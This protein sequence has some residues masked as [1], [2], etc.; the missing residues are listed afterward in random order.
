MTEA[1]FNPLDKKNLGASV[2]EALLARPAHLLTE[3]SPFKGAGVYALYFHGDF[4]AYARLAQRNRSESPTAPI[5]VGKAVPDGRRKGKVRLDATVTTTALFR[6]LKEHA[7]SI[8]AAKNLRVSDFTFRHLVVDDIWIPLGEALLIA[9]LGPIWN[10]LIDGFGNH[11]PGKGRYLG[12]C[13]RWDVLHP[14][15]EW[16][17][18]CEPRP[19]TSAQIAAEVAAHLENDPGPS[20]PYL[21]AEQQ[22]ERYVVGRGLDKSHVSDG[23]E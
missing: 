12:M 19:E 8:D 7:S 16:A 21:F 1:A 23:Q 14:G 3:L 18:K 15:R 11:D 13:S 17:K 22:R 4:P 6:R 2:A 5:Y 9:K 20:S 10:S